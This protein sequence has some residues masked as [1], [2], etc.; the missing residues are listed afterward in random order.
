MQFYVVNGIDWYVYRA[1][2]QVQGSEGTNTY[3]WKDYARYKAL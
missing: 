1:Y 2:G 3:D